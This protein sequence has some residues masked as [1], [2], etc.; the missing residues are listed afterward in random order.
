MVGVSARD[1]EAELIESI[2][3]VFEGNDMTR[4]G[5]AYHKIIELEASIVEDG[6]LADDILFTHEQAAPA[7][8]FRGHHK[9]MIPEVPVTKVYE[10]RRGPILASG[11]VD[12]LEGKQIRDTKCKFRP[13]DYQEYIDSYQWRFYV[14]M[15]GLDTFYYDF[16]EFKG[17]DSLQGDRPFLLPGVTIQG[18]EPL[19]CVR[20][21][22]MAEDCR[23]ML[24][25]FLEYIDNRNLWP[26]LKT[27]P[28]P[29]P[30]SSPS[31]IIA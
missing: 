12:G 22:H 28:D 26:L 21:R 20:Y 27:V 17:F 10:T 11:R 23:S 19:Q 14:D 3:G 1:T 9:N 15:L 30:L 6:L 24:N 31:K 2:K 16:F 29:T 5:G 4:V 18:H 8:Q 7:I 25:D 13:P